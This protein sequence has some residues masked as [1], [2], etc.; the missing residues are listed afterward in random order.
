[1]RCKFLIN[2][3]MHVNLIT[4]KFMRVFYVLMNNKNFSCQYCFRPYIPTYLPYWKEMLFIM[5]ISR[6]ILT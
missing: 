1:M 4:S 2:G 3:K 6:V 5:K